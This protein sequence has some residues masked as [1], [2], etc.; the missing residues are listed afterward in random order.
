VHKGPVND[1][2]ALE[3]VS[4]HLAAAR[5]LVAQRENDAVIFKY[6]AGNSKPTYLKSWLSFKGMLASRIM[7]TYN[8]ESAS[9]SG[10]GR[11]IGPVVSRCLQLSASPHLDKEFITRMVCPKV[12]NLLDGGCETHR[13][14]QH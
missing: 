5:L 9:G 4:E 13:Q 2:H 6:E 10:G 7:S 1:G 8:A 3:K 11:F 14:V 12:L